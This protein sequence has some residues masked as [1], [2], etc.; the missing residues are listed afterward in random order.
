MQVLYPNIPA[1]SE[2]QK[3]NVDMDI[4]CGFSA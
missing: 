2:T 3:Q 4:Y 1:V